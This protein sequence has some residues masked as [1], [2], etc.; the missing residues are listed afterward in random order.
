MSVTATP[1][2]TYGSDDVD[3][4]AHD[5]DCRLGARLV[6]HEYPQLGHAVAQRIG[7]VHRHVILA[8]STSTSGVVLSMHVLCTCT[9]HVQVQILV[10]TRAAE[11]ASAGASSV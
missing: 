2:N 1:R 9:V 10:R 11:A 6:Q 5:L 4:G 8:Q 3:P 7:H